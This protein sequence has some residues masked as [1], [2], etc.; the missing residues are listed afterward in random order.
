MDV[1]NLRGKGVPTV[2]ALA[3][4][5]G[6]PAAAGC[7]SAVALHPD[8]GSADAAAESAQKLSPR[9][10]SCSPDAMGG[11]VC[12]INFCGQVKSV[13]SL[14]P[15]ELPEAGA[16][17]LCTPGYV[18]VPD[19]ATADGAA[20]QLRCVTPRSGAAAFGDACALAGDG[21]ASGPGCADDRLCVEVSTAPGAPFCT[22]LCRADAD[23]AAGA[24]CLEHRSATLPDGSYATFGV[25]TPPAKL[26]ETPCADEAECPTGQGCVSY[27]DR[28]SLFVCRPSSGTKAVGE[29]C[30]APGQCRSGQCLD[31]D[32]HVGSGQNRAFCVGPCAKNSDCGASQRCVRLVPSNNGTPSDPRDDVVIGFCRTLYTATA[33]QGC[34]ADADCAAS[35][36]TT[37]G[38]CYTPGA[39]IG[40][41]CADGGDCDLG[42]TC[43][44]G[45]RLPGGYCQVSGCA[46]GATSGPDACPGA[47]SVCS[48]RGLDAPVFACYEGC[49]K[50]DDC[51]RSS[52]AAGG[53]VCDVPVTGGTAGQAPVICLGGG[54][55]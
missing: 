41:A 36:D 45:A 27:G 5:L 38:L 2:A 7:H 55:S 22:A 43:V 23:C 10:A 9:D 28:T 24:I 53:Y 50:T 44:T 39:E 46:P 48:Q 33:A 26:G 35:C 51:S 20:L 11:G 14:A 42:A 40:A 29:A 34:Q 15:G 12:P 49:A 37:T 25:C 8:G 32:G 6:A 30:S 52:V 4:C 21:G 16:D 3:L 31:R 13:A 17:A 1:P 19:G 47:E 18:C 54:G